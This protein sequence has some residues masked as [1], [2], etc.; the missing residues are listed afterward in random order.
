MNPA[1]LRGLLY[2]AFFLSGISALIYE[3]IWSKFLSLF[4]GS[5]S[6][7]HTVVL[8]TFMGGLAFGNAFFGRLA[9]RTKMD[10]VLLYA[11][12]EVGIGLFCLL[13]PFFFRGLSD[14]YL[15]LGARTGP[16]SALNPVLKISL[17]VVSIFVPCALMGGTLPVLAKFAIDSLSGLGFR[18]SWL[19]F[20]NTAGAVVGCLLGGFY[21]VERLGLEF[22]VVGTSLLNSAIG[23]VFYFIYRAGY[24]RKA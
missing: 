20:I 13:F 11:L 17:S 5:T 12:L 4:L 1:R 21:V 22:G 6:F 23:G 8:A 9:D 7:A 19:Y 24:S 10:K 3:V 18:L 16:T 14:V 2:L 15:A